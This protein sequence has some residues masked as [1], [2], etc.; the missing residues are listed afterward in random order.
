VSVTLRPDAERLVSAYLRAAPELEPLVADRI[1]TAMP[2][3]I[4]AEPFLLIQRIG[5][6]PPFPRP[7]VL[8]EALLQL[9]AYGGTKRQ[10]WTVGETVAQ[11]LGLL[12]GSYEEEVVSGIE[13]GELRWTPD[14][15]WKPPRPRY[16][17]DASVFVKP[18]TGTPP[19]EIQAAV[20]A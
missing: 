19:V 5:G 1:Y 7:L 4:G 8:D 13:V 16:L 12:P 14:E 3:R 17:L 11:L 9:D 2:A 18:E 15:T 10:A 6:S 20:T